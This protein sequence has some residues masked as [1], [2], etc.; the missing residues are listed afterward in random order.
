MATTDLY[1]G[2]LFTNISFYIILLVRSLQTLSSSLVLQTHLQSGTTFDH[3]F[4]PPE[5]AQLI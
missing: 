4:D 3:A 5:T 2:F 1:T